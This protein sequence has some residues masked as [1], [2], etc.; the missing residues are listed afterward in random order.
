MSLFKT[1]RNWQATGITE[2]QPYMQTR[3][4]HVA[5]IGPV[6]SWNAH[7]IQGKGIPNQLALGG[8]PKKLP[9]DRL[10]EAADCYGQC[11]TIW[12]KP[13]FHSGSPG[14]S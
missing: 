13:I 6:Q 14:S 11:V 3:S 4:T 5:A 12:P 7:R 10:P 1:M 8:W 9:G 2:R